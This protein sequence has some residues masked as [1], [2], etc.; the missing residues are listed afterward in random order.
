MKTR[1]IKISQDLAKFYEKVLSREDFDPDYKKD[2]VIDVVV[3]QFDNGFEADIKVCNTEDRGKDDPEAP[4]V[5]P[6]LF[7]EDSQEICCIP[8]EDTLLGEYLFEY[9]D[10]TYQVLVEAV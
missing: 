3:A 6:V 2:G 7:D 10:E 8:A 9:E 5:D 1:K 4:F